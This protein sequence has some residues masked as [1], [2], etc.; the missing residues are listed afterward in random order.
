MLAALLA[1]WLDKRGGRPL[2]ERR[3]IDPLELAP[4]L[5]PHLTL[6]D[7]FDRGTRARFRLVGTVVV[8][9]LGF[10]PTGRYLDQEK[11]GFFDL[12]AVLHRLV[13]CERAPVHATS[14]FAWGNDRRLEVQQLLLPLTQGGPDPAITLAAMLCRSTEPFP[15]TIRALSAASHSETQRRVLKS[16]AAHDWDHNAGRNVA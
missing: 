6:C 1:Y 14:V 3:D 7:L 5:L 12:V 16:L 2:P 10:D 11:S 8:Q 4:G 15:P 9:R 13:Y